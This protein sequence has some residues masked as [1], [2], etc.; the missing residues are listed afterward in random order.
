MIRKSTIP[1]YYS[2][3]RTLWSRITSGYYPAGSLIGTEVTL[4]AEFGVSR[5]TLREALSMLEG[6]GLVERRRSFGT[7]VADGVVPRG[8][9]EFTGYLEDIVLQADSAHT[10]YFSMHTVKADAKMLEMLSLEK[11]AKVVEVRRLRLT[12]DKP[13]L[14]LI[15]YLPTHVASQFTR[16]QLESRSLLQLLDGDEREKRIRYGHQTISARTGPDDVCE[17]LRL[18]AGSVVLYSDRVV[19]DQ[20]DA[21]LSYVEMYYPGDSFAFEIRLG[22]I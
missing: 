16:H 9:V 17:K 3:W 12:D 4:A 7:F 20:A 8:V 19:Y 2:I 5:V 22:R 1:R 13:R 21:P 15:D 6:E 18:S 14:W 10:A 11:G